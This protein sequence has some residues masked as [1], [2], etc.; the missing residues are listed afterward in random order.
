MGVKQNN[1]IEL[2][3]IEDANALDTT[4]WTFIGIRNGLYAFKRRVR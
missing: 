2:E 4:V 3:Q 1:F